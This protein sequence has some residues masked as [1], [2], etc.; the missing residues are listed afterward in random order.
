MWSGRQILA[1]S[2]SST[3]PERLLANRTRTGFVTA[4]CG[5]LAGGIAFQHLPWTLALLVF[6]RLG[7]SYSF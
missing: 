1:L 2:D 5:A 7:V 4:L 6:T 3:V